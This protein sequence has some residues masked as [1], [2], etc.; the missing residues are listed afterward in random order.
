M[1]GST[2]DEYWHR[3]FYTYLL[4]I[5]LQNEDELCFDSK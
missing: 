1:Q 4:N 2:C 3:Y 5:E